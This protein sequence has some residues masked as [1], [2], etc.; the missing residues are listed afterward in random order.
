MR[1]QI[2]KGVAM[3][4]FVVPALTSAAVSADAQS[5]GN[6]VAN[7]PF[8]FVVGDK[9]LP[10]GNYTIQALNASSGVVIRSKDTQNS[11]VRLTNPIEPKRNNT[12]ARLIFHRYGQRYFLSEVWSGGDNV[13]RRLLRSQQERSIERELAAISSRKTLA[14]NTYELVE[15]VATLD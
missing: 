2:L 7:V 12:Q 14:K 10:S 6:V 15:I 3:L 5:I 4:M 11:T 13:G 1:N 8:E 9:T